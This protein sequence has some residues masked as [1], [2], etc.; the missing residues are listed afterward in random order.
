[1]KIS[2]KYLLRYNGVDLSFVNG[3][4]A[5]HWIG[6]GFEDNISTTPYG[7]GDGS[8]VEGHHA[9]DRQIIITIKAFNEDQKQAIYSLFEERTKGTLTYLPDKDESKAVQIDCEVKSKQP[10]QS[11][12]PMNILVTLVCPYPHWRSVGKTME[13][14][15]G[16]VNMWTFPWIIP[17]TKTFYFAKNKLGNSVIFDY[18]GTI[19][20]GFVAT[21]KTTQPLTFIKL[22]NFYTKEFIEIAQDFPENSEIVINTQQGSKSIKWKDQ[23]A[24]EYIDISDDIKWGSK[25]FGITHGQNR[26]AISTSE[27]TSGISAYLT[28]SEKHG[29]A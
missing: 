17:R 25:Y 9:Y 26:I 4:Y 27:G 22:T 6:Y 28:F 19:A 8:E 15:C 13:Q 16:K 24:T 12:F 23:N 18:K 10:V 14:I 3:F 20:T 2:D 29:G 1:M 21:I 5:A 11:E 7:G